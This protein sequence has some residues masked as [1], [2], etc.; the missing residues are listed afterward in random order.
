MSEHIDL[1][2]ECATCHG[3]IEHLAGIKDPYWRHVAVASHAAK[4]DPDTV[5]P[6]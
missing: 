1:T 4:P 3:P 2:A 6:A 5:K